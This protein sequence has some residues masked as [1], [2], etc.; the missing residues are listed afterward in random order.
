M[1]EPG[2][3]ARAISAVP[4]P[5]DHAARHAGPHASAAWAAVSSEEARVKAA[6]A[7]ERKTANSV[8]AEAWRTLDKAFVDQK[9]GGNDWASVR[10][11]FV[12]VSARIDF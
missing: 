6:K 9:M 11:E 8:V 2:R 12:R 4:L 3:L 7:A 1:S 10:R 5:G